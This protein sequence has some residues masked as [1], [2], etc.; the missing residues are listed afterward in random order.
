M[1]IQCFKLGYWLDSIF[2]SNC[3]NMWT[4]KPMQ[5]SRNAQNRLQHSKTFK[6]KMNVCNERSARN[7][8][9]G[10]KKNVLSDWQ[11]RLNWN[12]LSVSDRFLANLLANYCLQQQ[13]AMA[14][15]AAAA[16][17]QDIALDRQNRRFA[18]RRSN[19]TFPL[20]EVM[21]ARSLATL[22]VFAAFLLFQLRSFVRHHA[23]I[24]VF[25]VT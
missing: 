4:W 8:V 25:A 7:A 10:F 3:V 19:S 2:S 15:A 5:K 20:G 24:T 14:A 21:C 22:Q 23:L 18:S 16:P 11:S 17:T 9:D 1:C 6:D 13:W 12:F